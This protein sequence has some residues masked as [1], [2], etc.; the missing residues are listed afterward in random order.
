MAW[1]RR[2]LKS[3]SMMN[4]TRSSVSL[5]AKAE[6]KGDSRKEAVDIYDHIDKKELK[7]AYLAAIPMLGIE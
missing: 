3:V 5:C 4:T 2:G 1:L 7:R 6:L